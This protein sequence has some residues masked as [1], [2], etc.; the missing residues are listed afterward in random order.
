M[1][2]R[3]N[4]TNKQ[5]QQQQHF[6]KE[7]VYRNYRKHNY[8]QMFDI[9]YRALFFNSN[10]NRKTYK[11]KNKNKKGNH[12]NCLYNTL[13][14]PS[15]MLVALCLNKISYFIMPVVCTKCNDVQCILF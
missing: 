8:G 3:K 11:N 4:R 1:I 7:I 10:C 13:W 9:Y 15:K 6:T 12:S 2:L 5:Q 14:L